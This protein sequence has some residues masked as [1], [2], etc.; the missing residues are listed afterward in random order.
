MTMNAEP[1]FTT[2]AAVLILGEVLGPLQIVGGL[3]VI[4]AIFAVTFLGA[5]A[6]RASAVS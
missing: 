1:V 4:G 2:I 5:R 3:M 6:R